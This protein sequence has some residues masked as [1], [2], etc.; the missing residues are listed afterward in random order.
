M[1]G[2][3]QSQ[4]LVLRLNLEF[5]NNKYANKL[6]ND[7]TNYKDMFYIMRRAKQKT[8]KS[9]HKYYTNGLNVVY[10]SIL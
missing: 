1:T 2:V 3:K 5:D 6:N 10:L 9:M 8:R 7:S 4:L